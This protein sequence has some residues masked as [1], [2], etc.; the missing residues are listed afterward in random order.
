MLAP[1]MSGM[2]IGDITQP[3]VRIYVSELVVPRVRIGDTASVTIDAFP[4]RPFRGRVVSV[5]DHAEFTPRV[6]LTKDE[7]ADLMFGIKIQLT[8]SSNVLKAGLPVTV[9]LTPRTGQ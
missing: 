6:A 5:S 1:G 8:D 2:T 9:H 7:R 3:Y 4:N